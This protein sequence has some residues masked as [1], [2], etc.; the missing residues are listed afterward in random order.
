M[1]NLVINIP[2]NKVI[3]KDII[4][5]T[6]ITQ[7]NSIIIATT[8]GNN[9]VQQSDISWS[10]LILGKEALAHINVKIQIQA[11]I[12]NITLDIVFSLIK[13]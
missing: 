1:L 8:I 13:L 9:I 12:P 11:L 5:V 7:G 10:N 6:Y 4:L 2:L 3:F